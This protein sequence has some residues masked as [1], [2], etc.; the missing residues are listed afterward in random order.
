[1]SRNTEECND[2]AASTT[3]RT[4]HSRVMSAIGLSLKPLMFMALFNLRPPS[5]EGAHSSEAGESLLR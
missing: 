1:M 3:R 2:E 5:H 4:S